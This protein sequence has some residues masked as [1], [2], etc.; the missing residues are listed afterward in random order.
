MGCYWVK[1]R[2]PVCISIS[3][4][5][6]VLHISDVNTDSVTLIIFL[7]NLLGHLTAPVGAL[8]SSRGFAVSQSS[9]AAGGGECVVQ[10]ESCF[11]GRSA[12]VT[13]SSCPRRGGQQS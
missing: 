8:S 5:C 7:T 9:C 2:T 1:R 11:G 13:P 3:I 4:F 10:W 6:V 12:F